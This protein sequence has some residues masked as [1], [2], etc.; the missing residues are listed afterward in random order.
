MLT[1]AEWFATRR[2]ITEYPRRREYI[3]LDD[4]QEPKESPANP[5][6]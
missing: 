6:D 5:Y 2:H 3:W 4:D 1:Y